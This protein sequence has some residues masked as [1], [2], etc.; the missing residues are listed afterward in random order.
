MAKSSQDSLAPHYGA[1]VRILLGWTFLWA[2]L[3]KVWGLGFTTTA[4]KSWLAGA[5]PTTGF[6]KFATHGPFKDFY[7]GLAG[8]PWVDWLFMLGLLLIGLALI[9]CIGTR[10]AGY[11]G[12]LLVVMMFTA[13]LPPE[14]NPFIDEHIIYAVLLLGIAQ[15]NVGNY[16][17]FGNAWQQSALVRRWPILK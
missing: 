13:A 15:S 16:L 6:L 2:F 1:L 12:A 17:G 8:N 10:I 9:L 7:V 11:T 4:D 5:S 3:D 14:H